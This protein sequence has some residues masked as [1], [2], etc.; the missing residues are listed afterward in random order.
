MAIIYNGTRVRSINYNGYSV[1]EVYY[2]NT[3]DGSCTKV[4][5][6][7]CVCV[8]YSS[9][10]FSLCYCIISPFLE[11]DVDNLAVGSSCTC[12]DWTLTRCSATSSTCRTYAL[13]LNADCN[14]TGDVSGRV[15]LRNVYSDDIVD[16][17]VQIAPQDGCECMCLRLKIYTAPKNTGESIT[18]ETKC[19]MSCRGTGSAVRCDVSDT[20]VRPLV[21]YPV[22]FTVP[23]TCHCACFIYSSGMMY[24]PLQM[25][26][27]VC[28]CFTKCCLRTITTTTFDGITNTHCCNGMGQY[29]FEY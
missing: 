28:C 19:I 18:S 3:Q 22:S 8:N 27:N 26:V 5:P 1:S 25:I 6:S 17:T 13:A 9:C 20:E 21:C 2:C 10:I 23:A 15:S 16:T 14:V 7:N 24:C 11:C 12:G 4:F 29:V